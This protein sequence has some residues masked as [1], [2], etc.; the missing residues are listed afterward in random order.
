MHLLTTRRVVLT[1]PLI[2]LVC[3]TVLAYLWWAGSMS[4]QTVLLTGIAVMVAAG[5][6][7][8]ALILRKIHSQIGNGLRRQLRLIESLRQELAHTAD[9]SLRTAEQARVLTDDVRGALGEHR[10]ELVARLE[11]T[12]RQVYQLGGQITDINHRVGTLHDEFAAWT[13]VNPRDKTE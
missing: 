6:A 10:V 8:T 2:G 5:F 1:V 11:G 3:A 4:T 9:R 7:A 13:A 12:S